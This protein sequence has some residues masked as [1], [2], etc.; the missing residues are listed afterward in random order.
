MRRAVALARLDEDDRRGAD[1]AA[2]LLPLRRA[3]LNKMCEAGMDAEFNRDDE[4]ANADLKG[5]RW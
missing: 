4:L 2:S 5:E 1:M 3:S